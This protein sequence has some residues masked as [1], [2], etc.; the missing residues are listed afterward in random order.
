MRC[1]CGRKALRSI[2]RVALGL[3]VFIVGSVISCSSYDRGPSGRIVAVH[4]ALHSIGF[5]RMGEVSE[6]V[7]EEGRSQQFTFDLEEDECHVFVAFGGDGVRDIN[8]ELV[9][10]DG[11]QLATDESTDRQ[12]VLRSCTAS[13]GR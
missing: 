9:S 2:T 3:S 4:N 6:G 7:L 11:E 8:L 1:I 5:N 10:P 13:A 12:A